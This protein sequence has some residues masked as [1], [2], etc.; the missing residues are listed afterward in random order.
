MVFLCLLTVEEQAR[1]LNSLPYLLV[2]NPKSGRGK[3]A[4]IANSLQKVIENL[5]ETCK[6]VTGS[7]REEALRNLISSVTECKAV[8]AVGGDGL[9]NMVISA[10][11]GRNVPIFVVAAGTGN[12]FYREHFKPRKS[13]VETIATRSLHTFS[14]D[15]A[16]VEISKEIKH[17]G[18]VLSAGFDS[19]V[20]AREIG[21]AHV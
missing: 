15:L 12:D 6:L 8:I 7:S 13:L 9:V 21:R 19:L 20:N 17:Y 3:A 10:T 4:K 18:Q 2:Y 1:T 16:K 14:A 11:I 5:G